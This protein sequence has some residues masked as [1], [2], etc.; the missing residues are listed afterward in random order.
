[1]TYGD[2][3][4]P[5]L[6]G[7]LG[8]GAGSKRLYVPLAQKQQMQDRAQ[9]LRHDMTQAEKKLWYILRGKQLGFKFRRQQA[10]DVYIADFVCLEK[11]LIV[12]LDGGQHAERTEYDRKRTAYL[13]SQG[14]RVLRFWNHDVLQNPEGVVTVLLEHLA[15]SPTP[16]SPVEGE[17]FSE[18]SDYAQTH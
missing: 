18:A 10:L 12:E 9:G 15:R 7:R 4:P 17:G 1:M 5:P 14:F 3:V 11:R 16:P 13:E 8:G 6:R 2:G